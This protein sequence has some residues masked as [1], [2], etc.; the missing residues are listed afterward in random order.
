LYPP[1]EDPRHRWRGFR[2]F[3]AA[4]DQPA[5][6]DDGA[7][8]GAST[9]DE[10][11]AIVSVLTADDAE[12]SADEAAEDTAC[13]AEDAADET[14]DSADEMAELAAS[15]DTTALEAAVVV[16]VELPRLKTQMRPMMIITATMMMIQ[17]LRFMNEPFLLVEV[18]WEE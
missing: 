16:L 15:D 13:S 18:V 8:A 17:V 4:V 2:I 6:E 7:I 11:G 10:A 3:G 9:D 5:D 12:A 14:A 1:N